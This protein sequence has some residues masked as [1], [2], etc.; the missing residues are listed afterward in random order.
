MNKKNFQDRK[1]ARKYA[2]QA[3]YSWKISNNNLHEIENHILEDK[4]TS[5]ID[6]EHFKK[7]TYEIPQNITK[8]NDIISPNLNIPIEKLDVIEL[9][10]LQ[11]ATFELT[12]CKEIPYKVVINE[13]LELTKKFGATESHK[14]VNGV[15]DKIAKS[16][17]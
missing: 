17:N 10:V 4:N 13:A 1:N 9:I 2:L 7:L 6:M 8:L 12:N 5:K 15:I 11:I 3:L 14:F 16:L